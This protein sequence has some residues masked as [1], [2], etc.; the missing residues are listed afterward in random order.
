YSGSC[1]GTLVGTGATLNVTVNS[2]TTYFVRA[3]GPCNTTAC[4]SVTVTVNVQPTVSITS[5]GTTVLPGSPVILTATPN[6]AGGTITWYR[7]GNVVAG[8]T[9]TTLIVR[10]ADYGIYTATVTTAA[11][12]IAQQSNALNIGYN[13]S[14]RIWIYPNP[15][16]GFF[17]VRYYNPDGGQTTIQVFNKLGQRVFSKRAVT[18]PAYERVDVD[19]RGAADGTYTVVVL[20]AKGNIMGAAHVVKAH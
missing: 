2:T 6:P 10:A 20:D 14:K 18:G 12:C 15:T 9:G 5:T 4:A 11:G 19:L 8:A 13:I 3:E 17:Q 7:D 16:T 1:G